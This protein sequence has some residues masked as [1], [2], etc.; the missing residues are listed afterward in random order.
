MTKRPIRDFR[1]KNIPKREPRKRFKVFTDGIETEK[2]Y[3][4]DLNRIAYDVIDVKAKN[5]ADIDKLV[6]EAI[7][8]RDNGDYDEVCVVCDIDERLKSPKTKGKLL[9]AL[10]KA[11]ENDIPVY[12]SHES[13]DIW[14]LAHFGV[15]PACAQNR[16]QASQLLISKA[17]MTGAHHKRFKSD[18]I[19]A[20]SVKQAKSE[21][22]R[23]RK[24]YR[25]KNILEPTGPVTD[26]DQLIKKIR[27]T[28]PKHILPAEKIT[29]IKQQ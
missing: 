24:A 3:F 29:V 6:D 7:K 23:L 15:V 2:N 18:F 26:V 21:C 5:S 14:L 10:R 12:L 22:T 13:F 28:P 17:V 16:T 8:C 1:R 25:G 20:P 9:A 11:Q 27:I 4:N 19:S